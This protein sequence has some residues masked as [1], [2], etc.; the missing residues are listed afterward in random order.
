MINLVTQVDFWQAEM[1][2]VFCLPANLNSE[3]GLAAVFLR[4]NAEFVEYMFNQQQRQGGIILLPSWVKQL[5]PFHSSDQECHTDVILLTTSV[6]TA[7]PSP[8][9]MERS[10]NQAIRFV[11]AQNFKKFAMCTKDEGIPS[12]RREWF[13]LAQTMASE[14]GVQ[15]CFQTAFKSIIST[16]IHTGTS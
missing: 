15:I 16:S 14:F 7:L 13:Q 4:E 1:P 8:T 9:A 11:V 3:S 2:K 10:L 5:S 6:P 12:K